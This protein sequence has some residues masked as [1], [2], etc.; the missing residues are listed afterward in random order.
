MAGQ[1]SRKLDQPRR[2][3]WQGAWTFFAGEPLEDLEEVPLPNTLK[4]SRKLRK[5][6]WSRAMANE[7]AQL[8]FV[9]AEDLNAKM[10][11]PLNRLREMNED[12][13]RTA[14]VQWLAIGG[15]AV[16]CSAVPEMFESL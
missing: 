9:E 6:G 14:V 3:L 4:R 13:R 15:H 7:Q 8:E 1:R 12:I 2:A 10:I 11:R 16:S 5:A